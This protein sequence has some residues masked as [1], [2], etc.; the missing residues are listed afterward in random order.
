MIPFLFVTSPAL[1]M[2]GSPPAIGVSFV[3]A[4]AGVWLG[5]AAV[6]GY[7][8]RPLSFPMRMGFAVAGL[9]LLF[10]THVF[11]IALSPDLVGLAL[12][13]ALVGREALASSLA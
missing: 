1:L 8:R 10:P 9:L 11:P 6:V 3:T 12:A 13:A 2:Q 5:S 7:F 4:F